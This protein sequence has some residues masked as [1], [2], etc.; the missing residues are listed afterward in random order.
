MLTCMLT[1]LF[2][3]NRILPF[4]YYMYITLFLIILNTNN[5]LHKL[6]FKILMIIY[7]K[8]S[9]TAALSPVQKAITSSLKSFF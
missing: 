9:V 8:R 7:Y 3:H 5:L 6:N 4:N 1:N 2:I